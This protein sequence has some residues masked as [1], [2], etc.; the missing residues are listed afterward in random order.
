MQELEK[1]IWENENQLLHLEK[2]INK[3][4][5]DVKRLEKNSLPSIFYKVTGKY[6][7]TLIRSAVC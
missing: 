3:E 7:A 1:I 2:T 5:N 6:D 4:E